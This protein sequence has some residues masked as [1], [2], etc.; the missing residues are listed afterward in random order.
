MAEPLLR[1]LS[2]DEQVAYFR[3]V[4]PIWGGG[5]EE[6]RFV[7]F[8]RRMADSA[9]AQERF[10]LLGLFDGARLLSGMKAYHLTGSC[11]GAL[12]QLLGIGAVFTPTELRRRGHAALMLRLAMEQA[13]GRGQVA[14]ILFSDIGAAYYQR[15]GFR[16]LESRECTVGA[17]DLPYTSGFCSAGPGD[18]ATLSRLFSSGRGKEGLLTLGRGGFTLRF[19]LRRLRE[20]ARARSVREP[21]WGLLVSGRAGEGGAVVRLGRDSLDVLDAAWTNEV[22]REEVL[23]GLRDCMVRSG[24][25]KLR[26]WPSHQLRDLFPSVERTQG[27]AM[28]APLSGALPLPEAGAPAELALLDHI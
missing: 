5:L 23:G 10:R 6:S 4:Q 13:R 14:A 22:A 11:R 25:P 28:I 17:A 21:E 9:E 24:R 3:A 7:S 26:L 27:L 15:L 12:L 2:V 16:L 18:E 8:Q 1:E 20:L 19:Q